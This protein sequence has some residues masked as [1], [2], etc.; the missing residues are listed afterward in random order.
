MGKYQFF[1]SIHW[2]KMGKEPESRFFRNQNRLSTTKKEEGA[3][4]GKTGHKCG[5]A[6]GVGWSMPH[7]TEGPKRFS[8]VA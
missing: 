6:N 7:H 2:P 8:L 1:F 3:K 5:M 4:A